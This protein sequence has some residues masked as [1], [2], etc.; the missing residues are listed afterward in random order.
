MLTHAVA[1]SPK[2]TLH[3]LNTSPSTAFMLR[4]KTRAR[5]CIQTPLDRSLPWTPRGGR[6]AFQI[7]Y[8]INF[9]VKH[10]NSFMSRKEPALRR[11]KPTGLSQSTF[12]LCAGLLPDR[13]LR[14]RDDHLE[15]AHKIWWS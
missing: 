2:D 5:P 6:A 1:A 8:P 12:R 7:R 4:L 14:H 13:R 11:L 15:A 3:K 9:V 10:Q